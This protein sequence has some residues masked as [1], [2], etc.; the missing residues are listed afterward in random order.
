M[1]LA[2]FPIYFV[3]EEKTIHTVDDHS[4]NTW[5]LVHVCTLSAYLVIFHNISAYMLTQDCHCTPDLEEV[6]FGKVVGCGYCRFV[7]RGHSF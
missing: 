7:R 6:M 3:G 2:S 4:Q 5:E 1:I